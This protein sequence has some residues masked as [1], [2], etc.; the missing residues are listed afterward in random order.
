MGS[1]YF[2]AQSL[3][4]V[5]DWSLLTLVQP[6]FVSSS[7][8]PSK[9]V[10]GGKKRTARSGS[11]KDNNGDTTKQVGDRVLGI[12]PLAGGSAAGCG[13]GYSCTHT[14][15][16]QSVR[17]GWYCLS[18]T[19]ST[20]LYLGCH[21]GHIGFWARAEITGVDTYRIYIYILYVTSSLGC[22]ASAVRPVYTREN[23]SR[24]RFRDR[25]RV[26]F[27]SGVGVA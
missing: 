15:M 6:L 8:Y 26:V 4:S 27:S 21:S 10:T 22:W 25:D 9:N 19:L 16:L 2:T 14:H 23:V 5:P 12:D 7:Y 17:F 11:G 1:V 24:S 20:S 3:L 18:T 13:V